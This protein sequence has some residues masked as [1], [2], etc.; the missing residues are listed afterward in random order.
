MAE[1]DSTGR[2]IG[3]TTTTSISMRSAPS[4]RVYEFPGF[5]FNTGAIVAT[6]GILAWADFDPLVHWER[7]PRH[8]HSGVFG[9]GD[10]SPLNYV[11]TRKAQRGELSLER[12]EFMSWAMAP[13]QQVRYRS[14]ARRLAAPRAAVPALAHWAGKSTRSSCLPRTP[15]CCAATTPSTTGGCRG[16]GSADA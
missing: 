1:V 12:V 6:A 8:A 9:G 11:L 3:C 2:W 4:I 10:R 7:R 16:V 13:L 5:T 15:G 14:G